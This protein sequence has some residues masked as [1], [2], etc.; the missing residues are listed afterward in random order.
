MNAVLCATVSGVHDRY[1][2]RLSWV[3]VLAL[4]LLLFDLLRHASRGRQQTSS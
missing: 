1:Q 3:V 2:A 4:L